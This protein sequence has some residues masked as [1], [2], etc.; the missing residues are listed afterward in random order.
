MSGTKRDY[1]KIANWI[2]LLGLWVSIIGIGTA[3][4]DY[5][6]SRREAH[7]TLEASNRQSEVTLY[8]DL[9]L[10]A[11]RTREAMVYEQENTH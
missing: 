6:G 9:I 2:A 8:K 4:N 5:F 1:D 11:S 7:A 3:V 10:I